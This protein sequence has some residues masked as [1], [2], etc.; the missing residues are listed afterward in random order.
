MDF[1]RPQQG[2]RLRL[3]LR[4]LYIV[5]TRFG[6]LWLA[7][8]L[9]LQVV[10]IQLQSNGPLLLSFLMLGLFLLA[11]HLTHFNLQGL[12]LAVGEPQPGFAGALL[13]YPLRLRC[14]SR[15]EGLRLG[16][17][18]GPP[19]GPQGFERGDHALSLLWRPQARGLQQPG[20]LR[21]QTTA[22][23]GLFICWTRW[24]PAV[25]QLVWPAPVPGPVR[26]LEQG[27][28]PSAPL[29]AS[30]GVRQDGSD[31][32]RDLQPH[33]PEDGAS[34]L[35][36]KLLAQGR[37]RYAKR[38]ADP[39]ERQPLL[40]L[41]P[42]VPLERGLEHLSE[43]ICRL[44]GR[45]LAYGLVLGEQQLPPGRGHAQRDLALTALATCR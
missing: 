1:A 26:L 6:W 3:G 23:L 40:A 28:P 16:F 14:P 34:R 8:L 17:D 19:L 36:W 5:P 38:F 32:W 29:Q 24:R 41:D 22:P 45:G 13:A 2:E 4:N 12:E 18:A 43:R 25:P 35:A 30:G 39:A 37:G 7:G 21:L 20:C 9:L 44:H 27:R 33:R 15:C 42:S 10:G 31:D 11:L